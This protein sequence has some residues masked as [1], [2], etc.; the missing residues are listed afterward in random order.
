VTLVWHGAEVAAELQRRADRAAQVGAERL[1][2]A[3]QAVVPDDPSDAAGSDLKR[4]G[5]VTTE[6]TSH[7]AEAAVSYDTPYAVLQHEVHYYRHRPG[8]QSKFLEASMATE[9]TGLRAIVH[10]RMQI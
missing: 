7:G 6:R 4:S 10:R 2:A 8:Q 9:L 5:K 1:F 3:S